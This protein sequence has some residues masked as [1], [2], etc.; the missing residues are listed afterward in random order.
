MLPSLVLTARVHPPLGFRVAA[1]LAIFA[2]STCAPIGEAGVIVREG[3]AYLRQYGP[4]AIVRY[5][6]DAKEWLTPIGLRSQPSAFWLD[7]TGIYV[8]L[9][10][11]VARLPLEGGDEQPIADFASEVI[12]IRTLG[13]YVYTVTSGYFHSQIS[14]FRKDDFSPV[15]QWDYNSGIEADIAVDEPGRAMYLGNAW[16]SPS[17][18]FKLEFNESGIP[19]MKISEPYQGTYGSGSRRF[20]LPDGEHVIEDSGIVYHADLAFASG[21]NGPFADLAFHGPLVVALRG[22]RAHVYSESLQP[23]GHLELAANGGMVAIYGD[24]LFVFRFAE[25]SPSGYS[26]EIVDLN[27]I[28]YPGLAAS[29]DP[30]GLPVLIDDA[31]AGPDGVVYLLSR[32]RRSI[33][34]YSVRDQAFLPTIGLS[35]KPDYLSYS[36]AQNRIYLAYSDGTVSQIDL[37]SGSLAEEAFILGAESPNGL[38]AFDEF[39]LVADDSGSP[40]NHYVFNEEGGLVRQRP[41]GGR[42]REFAWNPQLRRLFLIRENVWPRRLSWEKIEIDG[43]SGGLKSGPNLSQDTASPLIRVSPDGEHVLLGSGRIFDAATLAESDSLSN[44]VMDAAWIAGSLFTIKQDAGSEHS[45]TLQRWG[46]G[47][48]LDDE[49][50]LP[51]KPIRVLGW[52]GNVLVLTSVA[53]QPR[54]YRLSQSF[55]VDFASELGGGESD[56]LGVSAVSG[57]SATLEWSFDE[58]PSAELDVEVF[59]HATGEWAVVDTVAVSDGSYTI[60][61]LAAGGVVDVRLASLEKSSQEALWE[62]A[63]TSDLLYKWI[64][65]LSEARLQRRSAET[66][67]WTTVATVPADLTAAEHLFEDVAPFEVYDLRLQS[68]SDNEIAADGVGSVEVALRWNDFVFNGTI[69]RQDSAEG[70]WTNVHDDVEGIAWSATLEN[71]DFAPRFRAIRTVASPR[72][73]GHATAYIPSP[74]EVSLVARADPLAGG[75]ATGS[76]SYEPGSVVSLSAKSGA[77]FVF[78][79]WEGGNVADVS[80][81]DTTLIVEENLVITAKFVIV[82]ASITAVADEAG[83][84][85]IIETQ[86]GRYHQLETSSDLSSWTDIGVEVLGD[87]EP[88]EI[89]LGTVTKAI[90]LRLSTRTN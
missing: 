13:E 90:F 49:A 9:G 32:S 36:D 19:G 58:V 68:F 21:L 34:R 6:L 85:V 87:G 60:S 84:H 57:S 53:G 82:G 51:G 47:F 69:Q 25:S 17:G 75:R 4:S 61:G 59:D 35:G 74:G 18:I 45:T 67:N 63:Q 40:T 7:D 66:G 27:D 33:L 52:D 64:P 73:Y 72:V 77:S 76:G 12:S 26:V 31:F 81:P 89:D 71:H 41:Q 8:A 2:I 55:D 10:S 48:V 22:N 14:G 88:K 11:H 70:S 56:H 65:L 83:L 42:S 37:F 54:I 29:V 44:E 39:L 24:D 79:G 38:L 78:A 50:T 43:T 3:I 80:S 23:I 20:L 86:E 46:T 62:Q 30:T 1:T 16:V 5:D 28:A 15:G